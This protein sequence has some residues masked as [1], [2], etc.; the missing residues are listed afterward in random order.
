[1]IELCL[2][3]MRWHDAQT[4]IRESLRIHEKAGLELQSKVTVLRQLARALAGTGKAAKAEEATKQGKALED[5]PNAPE[6]K[7]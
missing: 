7:P 2:A 1:M 6:Q 4:Q 3:Q 5:K